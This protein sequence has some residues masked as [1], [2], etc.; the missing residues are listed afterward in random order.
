MRLVTE[1]TI[2]D[3]VTCSQILFT[4]RPQALLKLL[5]ETLLANEHQEPQVMPTKAK[6]PSTAAPVATISTDCIDEHV[7]H[8]AKLRPGHAIHQL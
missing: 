8:S 6:V 3:C 2:G 1:P 5:S 7:S 4:A